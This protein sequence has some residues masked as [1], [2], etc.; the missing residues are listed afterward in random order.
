[1]PTQT[2]TIA[3]VFERINEKLYDLDARVRAL[4]RLSDDNRVLED[5]HSSITMLSDSISKGETKEP[6]TGSEKKKKSA[7][8]KERPV[9][10]VDG[11]ECVKHNTV[12]TDPRF[13]LI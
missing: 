6:P 5:I 11:S 1:M 3:E 8:G 9:A 4:E 2:P 10:T 7:S 13:R 12:L